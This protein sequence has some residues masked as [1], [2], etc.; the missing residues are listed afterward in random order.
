M[1]TGFLR[2]TA[3]PI[4]LFNTKTKKLFTKNYGTFFWY[5]L[6][7][8]INTTCKQT[9]KFEFANDKNIVCLFYNLNINNLKEY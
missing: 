8:W 3:V 9:T 7:L 4:L 2:V 5:L 6:H 1:Y